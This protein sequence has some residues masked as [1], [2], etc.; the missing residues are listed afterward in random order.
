MALCLLCTL[1]LLQLEKT[2]DP[3]YKKGF[4][5]FAPA[6]PLCKLTFKSTLK[7]ALNCPF[8]PLPPS[9]SLLPASLSSSPP[10]SSFQSQLYVGLINLKRPQ[11]HLTRRDFLGSGLLKVFFFCLRSTSHEGISSVRA[12]SSVQVELQ[13]HLTRTD[14]L[15]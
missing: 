2:S 4:L 7:C 3:P 8:L 14:F 15:G 9:S 1:R 10:F 11:I 12:L 5:R 6:D 13:I